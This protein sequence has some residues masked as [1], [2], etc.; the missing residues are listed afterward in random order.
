MVSYKKDHILF[1]F[2]GT[3]ADSFGLFK[4][5]VNSFKD[6]YFPGEPDFEKYRQGDLKGFIKSMNTPVYLLPLFLA[7]L[8][9]DMAKNIESCDLFPGVEEMLNSLAKKYSLQ[10]LSCNSTNAING[11]LR[12]KNIEKCFDFVQGE[13]SVISKRGAIKKALERDG[14]YFNNSKVIYIGDEAREVKTCKELGVPVG[15]VTWGYNDEIAFK[16]QKPDWLFHQ[17]IEI[18]DM[19]QRIIEED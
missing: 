3:I 5:T 4:D 8:K 14:A 15:A 12:K 18:D 17:P 9:K 1:D 13:S 19:M 7:N 10:V 11:F 6:D 16:G 2:D